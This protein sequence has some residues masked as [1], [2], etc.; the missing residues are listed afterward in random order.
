MTTAGYRGVVE[1]E[2]F[3]QAICDSDADD[4]IATMKARWVELV[5]HSLASVAQ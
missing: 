2:I 3:N 5:R 4:V 1:V